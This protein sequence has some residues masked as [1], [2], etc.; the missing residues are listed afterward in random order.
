VL[1]ALQRRRYAAQV[2]RVYREIVAGWDQRGFVERFRRFWDPFPSDEAHKF[3]N[4]ELWFREAVFRYFVSGAP[5]M[6]RDLR[7]LDLGAGTGYFLLVCRHFGHDV[8]GLDVADEPL[9]NECFHFFGLPRVEHRIEPMQPLPELPDRFDLVTAFMTCFN[10]YEDHR[11]WDVEAWTF[12]LNDVRSRLSDRGR[13]VFK[14][15]L[16]PQ[17]GEYYSAEVRRAIASSRLFRAQFFL[18]YVF[19]SSR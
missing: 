12:F 19:L 17:T 8:L 14:L 4:L 18:D 11:P 13:A 1:H 3:L 6:G 16:N 2:D 15:N 5:Q 7:V 10:W 9:Y